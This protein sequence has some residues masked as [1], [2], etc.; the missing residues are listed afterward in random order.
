MIIRVRRERYRLLKQ[1]LSGVAAI[2]KTLQVLKRIRTTL[3]L[4][5]NVVSMPRHAVAAD[6]EWINA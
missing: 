6:R 4:W 5:N 2:A 3:L 1:R